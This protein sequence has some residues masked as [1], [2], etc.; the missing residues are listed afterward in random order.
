MK[1]QVY[2]FYNYVELSRIS[3]SFSVWRPKGKADAREQRPAVM[4]PET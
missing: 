1:K 4:L 3:Y 2:N